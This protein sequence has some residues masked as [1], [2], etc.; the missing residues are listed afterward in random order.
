MGKKAGRCLIIVLIVGLPLVSVVAFELAFA[1]KIYP[2]IKVAD[3]SV[4]RLTRE[5]ATRL[6]STKHKPEGFCFNSAGEKLCYKPE[7][8]DLT[9]HYSDSVQ[10]AYE[11]SRRGGLA[12]QL[13]QKIEL[14]NRSPNFPLI[15]D[16]NSDK[17]VSEIASSSSL[18]IYPEIPPVIEVVDG[19]VDI[20]SGEKGQDVDWDKLLA[21]VHNNLSYGR[22][23]PFDL[24]LVSV[25]KDYNASDFEE[26]K[27]R[28]QNLLNK[29]IILSGQKENRTILSE[30][31]IKF[32]GWDGVWNENQIDSYL[33]VL[34]QD[35]ESQPQDALFKFESGKVVAFSL[36]KD[37]WKLDKQK[38][39]ENLISCL[40]NLSQTSNRQCLIEVKLQKFEPAIKVSQINDFGIT[41]LIGTG[42][43]Y[44]HGSIASRIHNLTLASERI[45]GHLIAPGETFSFNQAVGE[46]SAKTGYQSAYIIQNGRTV[47]GDGGGV[48]QVSTTLFR[49]A[50]NSGLQVT[51]RHAHAYRVHYY[52]EGSPVGMDATVYSPS[53]DLK[54]KNDLS[55][56]I[57]IQASIDRSRYY[58]RFDF[59]GTSDGR[60]V[61][62]DNF[63]LWDETPPP[64]DLYID[65]PTLAPGVV[66]QIDWK[67]WGAKASFDWKV[68]R[69]GEVINQQTFYSNFKPWQSI[70]L[71]GPSN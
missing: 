4:E 10:Q 69:G 5:E 11:Y 15:F 20:V 8:I 33:E 68:Y 17:L 63:R 46:I 42:E 62:I 66:K 47:L 7:D 29:T 14:I 3:I 60:K 55:S 56:H 50:L 32:V 12:Y 40:D 61:V 49:A 21:K 59:Y 2:R 35:Y 30:E 22:K 19:Q 31:L 57:L 52:E 48:C 53:V 18:L 28:A 44:F 36:E 9:F 1:Q 27:H 43:S 58:L 26:I 67:A 23:E 38:L 13:R 70:Y 25:G 37:G 41:Q 6:L 65:D 24:P 64:A 45:N 51:E 34:S 54:F 16:Y 39:K 71:R